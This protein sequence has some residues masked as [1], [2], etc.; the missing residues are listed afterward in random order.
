MTET[1]NIS[2]QIE[3][4]Q[5]E[6]L[7]QI[8]GLESK[9]TLF[10]W[11]E[12]NHRDAI[13]QSYPSLLIRHEQAVAGFII[14]NFYADECHLLNVV[15]AP[16]YQRQGLAKRLI[17]QLLSVAIDNQMS[18][19]ILEVRESNLS[20]IALY[21]NFGFEQIGTRKN[22]YRGK[23]NDLMERENALVMQLLLDANQP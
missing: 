21:K 1:Y 13:E 4:V 5:I 15:V 10:P 16:D 9:A 14:F 20:A 23:E 18:K 6:D 2:F 8:L 22:Y 17:E 12:A 19:V 3:P 11:S 7:A